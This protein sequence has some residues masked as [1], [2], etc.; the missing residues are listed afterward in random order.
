M[1]MNYVFMTCVGR[2]MTAWGQQKRLGW[3]Y[4]LSTW[5]MQIRVHRP[6]L[7]APFYFIYAYLPSVISAA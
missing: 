1:F 6:F 4:Y 7:Y 3:V 2:F 5:L